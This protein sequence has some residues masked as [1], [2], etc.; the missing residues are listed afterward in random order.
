[1]KYKIEF[2]IDVPVDDEEQVSD[3]MEFELGFNSTLS[4]SNPCSKLGLPMNWDNLDI[5]SLN[6]R[7]L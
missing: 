6:V 3:W 2:I 4:Q 1:M 5:N 7:P